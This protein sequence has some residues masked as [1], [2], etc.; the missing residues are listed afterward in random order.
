MEKRGRPTVRTP[1]I[2]DAIL[3][4]IAEGRS[5]VSIL[6]SRAD[7]PVY[8]SFMEWV[9]QDKVLAERYAKAKED[10]ADYLA[11]ELL[12]IADDGS[13]DWM[14]T[15]DPE[16]PGWKLNGEHYQRSRL[17]VD[18]RKWIASKLKAKKYGDYQRTELSGEVRAVSITVE[19]AEK[20][21]QAAEK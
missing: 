5:L 19:H 13:N 9:S 10:Q 14:E 21:K 7:F 8:S 15:N 2:V 18:T 16:N 6:K 11:E 12:D 20:I 17:R 4:Q 1:E 3:T